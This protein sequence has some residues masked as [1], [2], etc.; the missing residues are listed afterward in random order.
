[1]VLDAT[2]NGANTS[3]SEGYIALRDYGSTDI[4]NLLWFGPEW[5]TPMGSTSAT[6]LLSTYAHAAQA[7]THSIKIRVN[8]TDYWIL[9]TTVGPH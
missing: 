1:M 6:T 4:T 8:A 3:G 5:D 7:S 2:N 9:L